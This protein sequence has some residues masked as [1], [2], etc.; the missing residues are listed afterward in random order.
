[1]K[2][3]HNLTNKEMD[4]IVLHWYT[5]GNFPDILQDKEGKD[6]EEILEQRIYN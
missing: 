2:N 3:P 1:M 6:L 5:K 4:I